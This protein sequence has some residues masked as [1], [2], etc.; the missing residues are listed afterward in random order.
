MSMDP[1][2]EQT[3]TISSMQCGMQGQGYQAYESDAT[4][5]AEKQEQKYYKLGGLGANVGS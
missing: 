4:Y 3:T 1:E 5:G 2:I